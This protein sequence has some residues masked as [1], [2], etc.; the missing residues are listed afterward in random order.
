MAV[1]SLPLSADKIALRRMARTQR[2]TFVDT[3]DPNERARLEAQLAQHLAPVLQQAR[4]VGAY[5][6]LP[7]EISPLPAVAIA[8]E[9]GATVA[10]PTF[11][12]HQAPFRFIAGEPL[13][14]GPFGILQ[15]PMDGQ[16][17]RPDL[18]LVPLVGIDAKG[19]RLGQGKGHYDRVLPDLKRNG[20]LL[21]GVGWE[22]QRLGQELE[23]DAWDVAMD[24]FASPAGL[25]F[26][27]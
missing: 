24:A 18:I 20:S 6:P 19:N 10:F 26:L 8:R 3:L 7:D 25:A 11:S 16:E 9:H 17:I 14:S 13:E 4:L 5:A 1:P 2:R 15:P 27:R 22:F 23:P 21:V 12:D